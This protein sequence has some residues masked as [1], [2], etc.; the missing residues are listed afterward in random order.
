MEWLVIN[1]KI[2]FKTAHKALN[3]CI[4]NIFKMAKNNDV[5]LLYTVTAEKSLQKRYVK[6]HGMETA[7]KSATTFMKSLTGDKYKDIVWFTDG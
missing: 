3:L 7:E 5:K 6:Y 2:G 4:E 1:K